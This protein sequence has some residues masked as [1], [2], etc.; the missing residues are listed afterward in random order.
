MP[1]AVFREPRTTAAPAPSLSHPMRIGRFGAYSTARRTK[2]NRR[3][4]KLEDAHSQCGVYHPS[5]AVCD[6]GVAGRT[7]AKQ[8]GRAM[9]G[10][11]CIGVDDNGGRLY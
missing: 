4:F 5:W 1:I 2:N 10:P 8:H 6:A 11:Q 7:V 3:E 9:A